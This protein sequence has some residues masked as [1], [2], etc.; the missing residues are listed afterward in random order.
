MV[1]EFNDIQIARTLRASIIEVWGSSFADALETG[2]GYSGILQMAGDATTVIPGSAPHEMFPKLL[3]AAKKHAPYE[4]T[5]ENVASWLSTQALDAD[6]VKY[7]HT[8]TKGTARPLSN[9]EILNPQ[10][11]IWDVQEERDEESL[12]FDAELTAKWNEAMEKDRRIRKGLEKPA[13]PR[14]QEE[15]E[16]SIASRL[17]PEPVRV[18]APIT[19]WVSPEATDLPEWLVEAYERAGLADTKP[20]SEWD[21]A[22]VAGVKALRSK[23]KPA[24]EG[25]VTARLARELREAQKDGT[26]PVD[27][28]FSW[29]S[30]HIA[31]MTEPSKRVREVN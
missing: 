13:P 8:R 7:L 24:N 2:G 16:A 23:V 27:D 26:L 29:F 28:I 25:F 20:W 10:R 19:Q 4:M 9:Q 17:N 3:A 6:R 12:V 21:A 14:T 30:E 1:T 31:V 11:T 5:L 15:I 22:T 18:E